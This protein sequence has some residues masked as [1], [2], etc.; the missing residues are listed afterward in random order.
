MSTEQAAQSSLFPT[1]RMAGCAVLTAYWLCAILG[2]GPGAGHAQVHGTVTLDGELLPR[3]TVTFYPTTGRACVGLTD[4]E[5]RYRL[6]Y[7]AS[8]KGAPIGDYFVTVS[9]WAP[10]EMTVEYDDQ[11]APDLHS[12]PEVNERV[13]TCFSARERTILRCEVRAET[14]RVDFHLRSDGSQ[15]EQGQTGLSD[16]FAPLE[17]K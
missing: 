15:V 16:R 3:A 12:A 6:A 8:D 4:D 11:K 5:G 2:C 7:S 14:S 9:T 10:S 17:G 13:P 1:D